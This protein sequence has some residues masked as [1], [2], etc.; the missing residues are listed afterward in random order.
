MPD[1]CKSLEKSQLR[2]SEDGSEPRHHSTSFLFQ[3]S[4]V[5]LPGAARPA[6]CPDTGHRRLPR[7]PQ[8]RAE[9][10]PISPAQTAATPALPLLS[11]RR[12]GGRDAAAPG[13]RRERRRGWR[14]RAP[15]STDAARR[16]RQPL[17]RPAAQPYRRRRGQGSATGAGTLRRGR[18]GLPQPPPSLRRA[19]PF[20]SALPQNGGRRA[21]RAATAGRADWLT[22]PSQRAGSLRPRA[23]GWLRSRSPLPLA[24]SPLPAVLLPAGSSCCTRA[25]PGPVPP[26]RAPPGSG[27]GPG[28]SQRGAAG[29]RATAA[30]AG[31]APA[32]RAPALPGAGVA[33]AAGSVTGRGRRLCCSASPLTKRALMNFNFLT[34]FHV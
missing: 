31:K 34:R 19:L 13:T 5:P 20:A 27:P 11:S 24:P 10:G 32:G 30:G 29:A 23:S 14:S 18:P 2:P 7:S 22:P 16:R 28:G 8:P 1:R 21:P 9:A 3:K 15:Q 4:P 25:V 33:G 6:G 26:S 12:A 17:S